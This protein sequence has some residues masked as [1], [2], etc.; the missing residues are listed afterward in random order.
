MAGVLVRK[1]ARAK[2]ERN[3]LVTDGERPARIPADAIT[4][5][6]RTQGNTLSM[7]RCWD[8]SDEE[9]CNIVIALVAGFERLDRVQVVWFGEA[10]ITSSVT[11]VSSPGNTPV[12]DMRDRHVD[13][14]DMDYEKLGVVAREIHRSLGMS[15]CRMF[16]R[17]D[18]ERLLK[19]AVQEGRVALGDLG[20]KVRLALGDAAP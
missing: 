8:A 17:R 20:E 15:R 3:C 13:A 14:V 4:A 19:H 12:A 10:D 16:S 7:W 11:L 9:I 2:W 6:L 5:D 1:I 18:V